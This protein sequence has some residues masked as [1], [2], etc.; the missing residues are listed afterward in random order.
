VSEL[1]FVYQIAVVNILFCGVL[2]TA[3]M[4][5]GILTTTPAAVEEQ[6]VEHTEQSYWN[7]L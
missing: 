7:D 3:T 6:V 1:L 5:A 2:V 4:L